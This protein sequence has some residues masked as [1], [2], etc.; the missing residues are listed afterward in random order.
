ME[1]Q[2]TCKFNQTSEARNQCLFSII[3]NQK[4]ADIKLVFF[5]MSNQ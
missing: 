4:C 5:M 2:K 3:T 1:Q